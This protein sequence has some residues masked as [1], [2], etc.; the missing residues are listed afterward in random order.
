MARVVDARGLP[1]LSLL[2]ILKWALGEIE[3][4]AVTVLVDTPESRENVQR[5][6]QSQ[7][8]QVEITEKDGVFRLKIVKGQQVQTQTKKSSDVVLLPATDWARVI[9]GWGRY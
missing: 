4:G 3:T 1:C 8:C 6:A 5:F 7:G 2:L 9:K